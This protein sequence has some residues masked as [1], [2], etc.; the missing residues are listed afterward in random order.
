[1]AQVKKAQVREAIL[2]SANELFTEKDYASTTLADIAR[3]AGVTMSNIYNYFDSKLGILFAVYEPWLDARLERLAAEAA[4]FATPREGLRHVVL[5]V[6]R[7]I[8]SENR[9][10]AL[11]LLQAIATRQADESYSRNLL[12][13][14]EASV[15]AILAAILPPERRVILDDDLLSHLL[16]M[17]FDGFALNYRLV[18][19]S[20][21]VERLAE[22]LCDL[23]LADSHSPRET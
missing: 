18:G 20:R 8:P 15:S 10:F 17:A 2:R 3:H 4:L 12:R 19:P 1:M 5:A 21:R 7:D 9:N 23:I 11:N 14:S 13:R 16:F 22:L 6:L